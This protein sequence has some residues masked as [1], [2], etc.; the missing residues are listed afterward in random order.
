MKQILYLTSLTSAAFFLLSCEGK[1]DNNNAPE[2]NSDASSLL[3]S[4]YTNEAPDE[5]RQ[6]SEVFKDPSPGREVVV[7]GEVM[8]RL[9]PF[10][11]DYAM[12]LLGDPTKV[13][14]CNRRPGD[15]CPTPWDNC[16][17]DPAVLKTSIATVQIVDEAGK[18]L[19][20]SLKGYQGL[21]ELSYV[22][23]KGTIA[24]GSNPQNL[25]INAKSFHIAKESPYKDAKPVG[26]EG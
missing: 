8:G 14:P 21:K 16:C 18:V 25:V 13:T 3:D 22:T 10:V 23:V 9:K 24:E 7:A 12:V 15:D 11:D 19:K 4:Y 2:A 17:D 20:T 26:G 5:A 1:K 6:I